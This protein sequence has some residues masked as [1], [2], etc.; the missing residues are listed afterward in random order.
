[1]ANQLLATVVTNN[2]STYTQA[3]STEEIWIQESTGDS[4]INAI[5]WFSGNEIFPQQQFPVE[6]TIAELATLAGSSM[7]QATVKQINSNS[8]REFQGLFSSLSSAIGISTG[9]S[10][11]NAYILFNGNKY[12]AE[13]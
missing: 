2:G 6:E 7:I 3:F 12:Y 13:E 11:I 10:G 4:D 9:T 8:Q 1:M 5:I